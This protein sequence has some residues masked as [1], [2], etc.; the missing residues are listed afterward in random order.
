VRPSLDARRI[1]GSAKN[2]QPWRFRVL[3]GPWA[4]R[5]GY[6]ECLRV[7]RPARRPAPDRNCGQ[8]QDP[9]AFDAGRA[10]ENMMLAAWKEGVVPVR[11]NREPGEPGPSCSDSR[12]MSRGYGRCFSSAIRRMRGTPKRAHSTCVRR[13]G[14]RDR[15]AARVARASGPGKRDRGRVG[16]ADSFMRSGSPRRA[17]RSKGTSG[18]GGASSMSTS[19]TR[20]AAR[21]TLL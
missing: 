4:G 13:G 14:V 9:V 15:L 17:T 7:S 5:P 10:A 8:R 16:L 21:C 18:S 11:R 3:G 12:R 2:R 20:S 6:G 1:A 19:S